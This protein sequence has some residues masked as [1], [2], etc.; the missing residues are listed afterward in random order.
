MTL[1]LDDYIDK[2]L[3]GADEFDKKVA[4]HLKDIIPKTA[5]L[6]EKVFNAFIE[7]LRIKINDG[8]DFKTSFHIVCEKYILKGDIIKAEL[9]SIL[10][11]IILNTRKFLEYIANVNGIKVEKI[12]KRVSSRGIKDFIQ[13]V[14]HLE[15]APGDKNVVFATFD[16]NHLENDPFI[17]RKVIDIV[18]MLALPM[19]DSSD[20]E[21]PLTAVKLK[22]RNRKSS[23]KKF[24]TFIDAGW[25]ENFY[26]ADE[27]D[28]YG[29]TKSLDKS[30][31]NMPEVVHKNSKMSDV[32]K[33]I[34]FLKD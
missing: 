19:N 31:K 29:R 9:P 23:E 1:L 18:N 15:L 16:E 33:D 10:I 7:D 24:P 22:Y 30:L 14:G 12:E 2:Y 3:Q 28:V 25:Y 6:D 4:L 8:K 26:P 13:F 27:E 11:R 34:V 17:N 32:V 5:H 21:E 20:I